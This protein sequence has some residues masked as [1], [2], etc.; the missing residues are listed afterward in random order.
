ML[1]GKLEHL[2][3]TIGSRF[4]VKLTALEDVQPWRF[5]SWERCEEAW[6]SNGQRVLS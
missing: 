3:Q 4:K 1:D 5:S 6:E 2:R